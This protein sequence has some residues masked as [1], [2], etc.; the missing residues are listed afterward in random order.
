MTDSQPT[1]M[2][3]LLG[4]PTIIKG[5]VTQQVKTR[6]VLGLLAYLATTN[7]VHSRPSLVTLLWPDKESH[8]AQS[9]LR[10]ALST[11]K[12]ALGSGYL[13]IQRH[14]AGLSPEANI[15][16]DV[17]TFRQLLSTKAGEAQLANYERAIELYQDDFLAGF[18]LPDSVAFDEW[19]YYE[20]EALRQLY[21]YALERV[22]ALSIEQKQFQKAVMY[23]GLWVAFDPIHEEAHRVLMRLYAQTGLRSTAL[24]QFE[25]CKRVLWEQL[26]L[27]P[28]SETRAVYAAILAND[29]PTKK[30]ARV[31]GKKE[32]RVL[33]NLPRPGTPF[34]GRH[35]ELQKLSTMLADPNCHLLTLT[36][37]GGTGKTRLAYQLAKQTQ[38]DFADGVWLVNLAAVESPHF[39]PAAIAAA[40]TLSFQGTE[41][42]EVQ[43][44]DY[45]QDKTLLLLL[46]N[47][48]HLIEGAGFVSRLLQG[49]T[50]LKAVVTSREGLK[51]VEEWPY[52]V[53][54]LSYS[55]GLLL[56]GNPAGFL[57]TH[58]TYSAID[59]FIQRA[60]QAQHNFAPA[61]QYADINQICRLVEGLPLAIEMAAS[62]IRLLPCSQIVAEITRS[63]DFLTTQQ[64]NITDRHRSMRAVF[65]YSWVRLTA[66]EQTTLAALSVFRGGFG[67]EAALAVAGA[68]LF[69]L[70]GLMN[71][72]LV[73]RD[74]AGRYELHELLRQFSAEKLTDPEAIANQHS[75]YY[76]R[77]LHKNEGDLFG[78]EQPRVL[79][80][81]STDLENVY[82][83][84]LHAAQ[85]G[86]ID[87]L[88]KALHSLYNYHAIRCL[89]EQGQL[90]FERATALLEPHL[91]VTT[92]ADQATLVRLMARRGEFLRS[93]G[94]IP[95]AEALLQR[96]VTLAEQMG[97]Q[98]EMALC[99]QTLGVMAYLQGRY[100]PAGQWLRSALH[101]VSQQNDQHR[102]A[103][104]LMTLGAIE[105]ALGNYHQSQEIHQQGLALYE[106][107]EY[108]WGIAHTVRFLGQAAYKL[109]HYAEA[110]DYHQRCLTLS[111]TLNNDGGIALALNNLGLVAQA[112]G[113]LEK[114]CGYYQEAVVYSRASQMQSIQATSLQRLAQA[115]VELSQHGQG[116]QYYQ[117]ALQAAVKA[118]ETPLALDILVDM[119]LQ[120]KERTQPALLQE[121]GSLAERHPAS[122]WETQV[123]AAEL[124]ALLPAGDTH[125]L[126]P[127]YNMD[128]E[129]ALQWIISQ[130]MGTN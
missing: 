105:Q 90:L 68:N 76:A 119:A 83:A 61:K 40:L 41:P 96:A 87:H 64:R 123:K 92:P 97:L 116:Q 55:E 29:E 26:G 113:E 100:V 21:G 48:E 36:G 72:S 24:Q 32:A 3:N 4:A 15:T 130:V 71:K 35:D 58:N 13:D 117:M 67:Q 7:Q 30:S 86:Q 85:K 19:L 17:V 34:V 121:I 9:S 25:L 122:K 1:L 93:L 94:K 60:R 95:E 49:A 125:A 99:Y 101:I 8:K 11:L 75:H 53:G 91:S 102:Q 6:K 46:D 108:E 57:P 129:G 16:I 66:Q 47:F 70:Y 77:Y 39:I 14:T 56:V 2:L 128:S 88:D 43:L 20:K 107:V 65:D 38:A 51:L 127:T 80:N 79:E 73:R 114:A 50:K 28:E 37:L 52:E 42:L 54:G 33:G 45:L 82:Y 118:N 110:H 69:V 59:L 12:K 63:L 115:M 22:V 62:W 106:A 31:K 103:Y 98:D 111:Q 120:L 81:I 44:I 84:W 18:G 109:G 126:L 112:L 10:H 104:I 78:A 27:E 5:G 23:A 89:Y 74:P 124:V